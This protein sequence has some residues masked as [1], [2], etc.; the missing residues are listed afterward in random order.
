MEDLPRY[1]AQAAVMM[2][3]S[4]VPPDNRC[5]LAFGVGAPAMSGPC[6]RPMQPCT[7]DE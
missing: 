1:V 5:R 7:E 3:C 6:L 2:T 4:P